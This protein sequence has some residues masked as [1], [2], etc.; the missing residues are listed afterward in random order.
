[1]VGQALSTELGQSIIIDN[2]PGAG[3]NIRPCRSPC[4]RRRLHPV[5]GNGWHAR[6][7]RSPVQEDA[8]D[9]VKD[10]APLTRVANVPNLLVASWRTF[11]ANPSGV[12]LAVGTEIL[13]AG[14]SLA[15]ERDH[16]GG[17][18]GTLPQRVRRGQRGDDL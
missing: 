18:F 6:H 14:E 13:G 12:K 10:F 7:Q 8:L 15:A 4:S 11:A 9:L 2:R 1:M 5:H 3:G 17:E 16:A